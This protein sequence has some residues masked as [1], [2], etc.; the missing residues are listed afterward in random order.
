MLTIFT[1]PK[2]FD[3][4]HINMIQRNAI[5]SWKKLE[6]CEVILVGDDN[7]VSDVAR[8]FN[9]KNIPN[10]KRNEFN[11]PLLD[12]AFDLVKKNSRHDILMYI[13]ADIIITSDIFEALKKIPKKKFLIVG[14]RIDLDVKNLIDFENDL[15]E[16]KLKYKVKNEGKLHS[17]AGIDYFIFRK[18]SFENMPDFAVGRIGWDNWMI[19]EAKRKKIM[20]IDATGTICAIHQNHDYPAINKGINRKK[21]KEALR[22]ISFVQYKRNAFTTEDADWKMTKEGLRKNYMHKIPFLKRSFKEFLRL[23]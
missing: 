21:N 3:D 18:E 4:P 17:P 5:L 22:N 16:N 13:N 23:R 8:E 10:V 9:I 11:T 2:S 19:L 6:T 20:V 15:W 7:G 1:I 12:S 14:R